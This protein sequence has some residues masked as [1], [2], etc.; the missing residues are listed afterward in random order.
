VAAVSL[1]TQLIAVKFN[2]VDAF[3]RAFV[4]RDIVGSGTR[5][6][7]FREGTLLCR[8]RCNHTR[9]GCSV[10]LYL[11]PMDFQKARPKRQNQINVVC[12]W[13]RC[14]TRGT[15][16]QVYTVVTTVATS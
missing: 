4:P 16:V 7:N 6:W 1:K 3:V 12:M 9:K 2:E 11:L 14:S 13:Y 8:T 5:E 10:V 15:G